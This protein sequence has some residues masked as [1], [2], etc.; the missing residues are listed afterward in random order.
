[1]FEGKDEVVESRQD[2]LDPALKQGPEPS[3]PLGVPLAETVVSE[4]LLDIV[5]QRGLTLVS[6]LTAHAD[7]S[8][9][10][11][12]RPTNG[13]LVSSVQFPLRKHASFTLIIMIK[14]K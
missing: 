6:I 4:D 3:E 12:F 14:E 1:M 2:P 11:S 10:H 7:S 5:M 9:L 8:L 13:A